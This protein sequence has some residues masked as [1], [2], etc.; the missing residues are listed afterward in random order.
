MYVHVYTCIHTHIHMYVYTCMKRH[1]I[2]ICIQFNNKEKVQKY[3]YH[4]NV[5]QPSRRVR[6]TKCI[7]SFIR[8]VHEVLYEMIQKIDERK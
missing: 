3:V 1:G 4:V 5:K 7:R 6:V 2:H 8:H